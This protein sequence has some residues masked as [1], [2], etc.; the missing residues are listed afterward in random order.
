MYVSMGLLHHNKAETKLN[1]RSPDMGGTVRSPL[2]TK[3]EDGELMFKKWKLGIW[4]KESEKG[5][6]YSSLGFT[7]KD[8]EDERPFPKEEDGKPTF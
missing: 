8:D 4:A 1:E 6:P 3:D 5:V 2:W 7:E